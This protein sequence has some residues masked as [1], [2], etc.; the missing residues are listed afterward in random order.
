MLFLIPALA[1]W[2]VENA[3]CSSISSLIAATKT[4]VGNYDSKK[5]KPRIFMFSL[6]DRRL[7]A[8]SH[9]RSPLEPSRNPTQSAVFESG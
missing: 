7:I 8:A 5:K 4:K 1:E 3:V 2:K 6:D 9:N